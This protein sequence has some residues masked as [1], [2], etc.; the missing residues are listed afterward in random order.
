MKTTAQTLENVLSDVFF[1]GTWNGLQDL[2][3]A[4]FAHRCL[5]KAK[6]LFPH[7]SQELD[8]WVSENPVDKLAEECRQERLENF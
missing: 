8:Q 4:E 7:L 5:L 2:E 6:E 1:H 3:L